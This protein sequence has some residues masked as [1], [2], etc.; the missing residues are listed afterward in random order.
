M[1][2]NPGCCWTPSLMASPPLDFVAPSL[3]PVDKPGNPH[4]VFRSHS[5]P[6][7]SVIPLL[8]MRKPRLDEREGKVGVE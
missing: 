1:S 5:R 4:S 2:L 6:Q 3:N 8:Q 7:E